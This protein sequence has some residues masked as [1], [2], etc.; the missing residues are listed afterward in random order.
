MQAKEA[1]EIAQQFEAGGERIPRRNNSETPQS[2]RRKGK[3]TRVVDA[4]D[5]TKPPPLRTP[6]L[7][8]PQKK[9]ER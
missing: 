3:E 8:I 5:P 1:K 6:P 4:R 2:S 7:R 9:I